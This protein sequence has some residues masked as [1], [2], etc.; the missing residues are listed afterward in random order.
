MSNMYYHGTAGSEI[1]TIPDNNY[2]HHSFV[3]VD[4]ND[5]II[6]FIS[7]NI[8]WQAMNAYK[9]GIISFDKGNLIFIKDL[10]EAI[11]NLFTVYNMNRIDWFCFADN[12]AI[13]GY[14]NFI[15]RHGGRETAY[16]RSIAKLMDGKLHDGVEFEILKEEFIP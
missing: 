3:S 1:P 16:F 15:K 7:Y 9:F 13:R 11:N 2:N 8:D 14:R 10:N 12:P 4:K 6:G 5:K